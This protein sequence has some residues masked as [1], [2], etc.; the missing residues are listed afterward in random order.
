MYMFTAIYRNSY[1]DRAWI[2]SVHCIERTSGLPMPSAAIAFIAEASPLT[3]AGASANSTA[4]FR[5]RIAVKYAADPIADMVSHKATLP[6]VQG[7]L[8]ACQDVLEVGCGTRSTALRLAPNLRRL[9]ATGVSAGMIAIAREKLAA[10]PVP[11]LHFAVADVDA[12][13]AGLGQ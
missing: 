12:A 3:P 11:Q 13:V 6:R 7:L 2:A 8:P 5:D 9:L 4:R 10:Q 1:Q